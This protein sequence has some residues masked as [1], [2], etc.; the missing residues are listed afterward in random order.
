MVAQ[1]SEQGLS[2]R[3]LHVSTLKPFDDP[4]VLAALSQPGKGVLVVENH[5]IIGGLG[6]AVAEVMAENAIAAPLVRL[7]M[8]D[9]YAQGA[10]REYLMAKHGI[11]AAGIA[12]AV[13]S[14]LGCQIDLA[15]PS[16]PRPPTDQPQQAEDL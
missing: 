12:G 2:L 13:G 14:L 6:S 3:H 4:G 16:L 7:G 8:R 11:D 15:P 1:A 5:S 9:V 10:S